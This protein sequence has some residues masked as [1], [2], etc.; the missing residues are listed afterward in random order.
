MLDKIELDIIAI[1]D[2]DERKLK[3]IQFKEKY[4]REILEMKKLFGD[5]KVKFLFNSFSS[6]LD[7]KKKDIAGMIGGLGLSG[8]SAEILASHPILGPVGVA[9]GALILT[10]TFVSNYR[11]MKRQVESNSF[12][13]VYFAKQ[14]G[15]LK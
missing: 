7:L 4:E 13:Y 9:A 15:I 12:S 3:M 1:K 2:T 14:A 8:S 11:E 5:G 6:L 10:G